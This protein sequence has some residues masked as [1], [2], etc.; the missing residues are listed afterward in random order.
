MARSLIFDE[1]TAGLDPAE[2]VRLRNFLGQLARD[3]VVLLS[4]HI[5]ADI[6]SACYR[7]ALLDRGHVRFVGA[8]TELIERAAGK[9]WRVHT[10]DAG[11]EL[12]RSRY[13]ITS[14]IDTRRGLELRL[15]ADRPEQGDWEVA[16]PTLEDAYLWIIREGARD[17]A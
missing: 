6:G 1:P 3:R 13:E 9:V 17:A 15:L 8:R 14:M 7:L 5:V 11:H 16:E 12:L 10:N 2:R 4:T